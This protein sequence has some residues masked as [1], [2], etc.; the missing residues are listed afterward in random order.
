[1]HDLVIENARVID[2]LGG[3]AM[4]G[5]VARCPPYVPN[6]T[7]LLLSRTGLGKSLTPMHA[8]RGSGA[9]KLVSREHA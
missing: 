2:G 3:R 4:E 9:H 8:R 5:G 7:R 6:W 1:M